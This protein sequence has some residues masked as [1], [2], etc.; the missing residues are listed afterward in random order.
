MSCIQG[1]KSVQIS[2]IML[3][4]AIFK[5]GATWSILNQLCARKSVLGT[6]SHAR[7]HAGGRVPIRRLEP[8]GRL[9]S[10]STCIPEQLF[11][12]QAR[13]SHGGAVALT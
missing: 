7:I 12:E 13:K 8:N 11:P 9:Q 5:Y 10:D 6:N 4:Y 2:F 1:V 3:A